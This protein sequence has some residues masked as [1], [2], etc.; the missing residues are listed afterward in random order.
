MK[1]NVLIFTLIITGALCLHQ[2][3]VVFGDGEG[4]EGAGGS[5]GGDGGDG[6]PGS[7]AMGGHGGTGGAGGD[8]GG[9]GNG[10][11][12][13]EDH[14]IANATLNSNQRLSPGLAKQRCIKY[15]YPEKHANPKY[16]CMC[17]TKKTG[18]QDEFFPS[19][20]IAEWEGFIDRMKENRSEY[21]V[22][23]CPTSVPGDEFTPGTPD[24]GTSSEDAMGDMGSPDA[25]ADAADASDAAGS[26]DAAGGSDE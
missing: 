18:E 26:A 23:V 16:P 8:G 7:A 13:I 20:N 4:N 12:G 6:G 25:A 22:S 21:T 5:G 24:S 14:H 1:K 19:N 17:I 9:D 2:P 3:I 10:G 11:G 15:P